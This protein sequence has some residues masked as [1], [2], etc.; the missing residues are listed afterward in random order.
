MKLKI[1]RWRAIGPLLLF[2]VFLGILWV[3]FGDL[4]VE[5]TSEEVSTELLGTQVDISGLKL[6][7]TDSRIEISG[8]QIADPFNLDK[9]LIET[10]SAVLE[11]DPAAL[12][13]KKLVV[14]Q[15]TIQDLRL[16]TTRATPARPVSGGGFAP[17]LLRQVRQWSSQ[18]DVPLLKLTPIDTIKAL[19]LDPAQL[20]TVQAAKAVA[21][22]VDS[23]RTAFTQNLSALDLKTPL[24]SARVVAERLANA[25]PRSLGIAGTRDAVQSV[26]RTLSLVTS[27]QNRVKALEQSTETGIGVIKSG[28]TTVD[29]ARQKD[30]AFAKSLLQL[31]S[32]AAPDIGA[33]L[34]GKVSV[35]R[36]EKAVYWAEL[37]QRH[38]PP[39]LRPEERPA[40]RRL[41]MDGTSVRFPKERSYPSFLLRQ[42]TINLSFSAF[43]GSHT[44]AAT[45][46]GITSEPAIHGQ[47]ATVAASGRIG[48]A[49]PM[50]LS[51]GA[52]VD[53]R[54]AN[55][56]DS[57]ELKL[58]G[59][60]LPSFALPGLPFRLEPGAGSSNLS[61]SMRGDELAARWTLRTSNAKWTTDSSGTA[62]LG[63]LEG[64]VWRVLSGLSQLDVT[65]ELSGSLRAPRFSVRSNI[66]EAIA[67][68]IRGVLGEELRAAETRVRAQVDQLVAGEVEKIRTQVD[69]ATSD[70][71]S[72]V[73]TLKQELET[74]RTQL[75][76]RLRTLS[77]GLGGALGL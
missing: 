26:R 43:G 72:R 24:D 52:V 56:R 54:T 70:L 77:G 1:F 13:E 48:G 3:L 42:G 35:D 4:L 9:N 16:G 21:T 34:F 62:A 64:L 28:V 61:F 6:R 69:S 18:F 53:H 58:E 25:N 73:Q 55:T 71:R 33:A 65:A 36:F 20:S 50:S 39:G 41:R 8:I 49:H 2:L 27:A 38:L 15:L 5:D 45:A 59:V 74:A 29:Q 30:Y 10:G 51:L 12:L 67:D 63:T 57:A 31:P 75:E 46:R 19:V 66:D 68:R 47:P 22:T 17:N 44:L 37:A 23:M 60:P 40:P 32:F 11:L 76:S 7:E 14:N